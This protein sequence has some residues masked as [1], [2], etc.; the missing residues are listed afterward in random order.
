MVKKKVVDMEHKL[1]QLQ[2]QR[3]ARARRRFIIYLSVF[4]LLIGVILYFQ[5]GVSNVQRVVVTGNDTISEEHIVELSD[6]NPEVNMWNLEADRRIEAVE[7][8][9]AVE[10]ATL[11]RSWP[12]T[13][14][15]DIEEHEV[16]AFLV[17]DQTITPVLSTG[18][19]Y[20]GAEGRAGEAPLLHEFESESLIENAAEELNDMS[21][22]VRERIS[23]IIYAPVE[24]D[25]RR[26]TVL[27]NDGNT[28]SSTLTDF[29]S[30]MESYP[31]V[32]QQIEEGADGII[33][34]RVNPYFESFEEELPEETEAEEPQ[35]EEDLLEEE[36][37]NNNEEEM[38]TAPAG[39]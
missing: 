7:A 10:A 19:L 29:A 33:H 13:V 38:D 2:E 30:R 31:S 18:V 12:T 32:A 27:M 20:E 15:I 21:A 11:S 23:N 22:P 8:H 1:P 24:N 34:M 17:E 39:T 3:K 14:T 26:I 5:S 37:M 4:L 36:E 28:V 25:S 9:E 35:L 6:L 16:A